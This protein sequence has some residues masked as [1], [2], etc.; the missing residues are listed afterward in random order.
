MLEQLSPL[1]L[2][3][4]DNTKCFYQNIKNSGFTYQEIDIGD[5]TFKA[6]QTESIHKWYR[7]TP[8]YSPNLVRFLIKEFDINKNHFVVDPFSGRGTT[9]IECQK[10]G[11]K[12]LGIEINPLLQEVGNK[13]LEWNTS[14][15]HLFKIYIAEVF[16]LISQY[17]K[18]PIE[19]VS[20]ILNTRIP[21]IHNVFRWGKK[22]F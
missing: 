14:Y 16:S 9:A 5:I 19:E 6:G 3:N 20:N 18:N 12:A 2:N 22:I 17:K 4:N 15:L 7:L 1:G 8:S 21:I 11:I 13:S 10:Y